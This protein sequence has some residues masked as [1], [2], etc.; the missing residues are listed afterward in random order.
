MMERYQKETSQIHAPAYLIE[1]TKLAM[2]EEETRIQREDAAQNNIVQKKRE[3]TQ[4]K[5]S[6]YARKWIFPIAAAVVFFVFVNV[7]AIVLRSR[8]GLSDSAQ[9]DSAMAGETMAEGETG[10]TCTTSEQTEMAEDADGSAVTDTDMP[11]EEA[12]LDDMDENMKNMTNAEAGS[13]GADEY[14][15]DKEMGFADVFLSVE[16]VEEIPDF[17]GNADTE[18]VILRGLRFY[19]SKEQDEMWYAYVHINKKKYVITG[20]TSQYTE[21]KAFVEDAYELLMNVEE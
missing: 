4:K 5:V 1:R 19:V 15:T 13:A 6:A 21:K 17:Y 20:E 14:A 9:T 8:M 7:S 2:Q 11:H 3:R 16:E 12:D 18:C 10:D